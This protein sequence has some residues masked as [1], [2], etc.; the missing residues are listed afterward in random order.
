MTFDISEVTAIWLGTT[1]KRLAQGFASEGIGLPAAVAL[2]AKDYYSD[3]RNV[4]PPANGK[5]V[6]SIALQRGKAAIT[7]DLYKAFR[8]V[9]K[10]SGVKLNAPLQ[11]YLKQRNS[12]GRFAGKVRVEIPLPEFREIERQ[13]HSR[14]GWMQSGWNVALKRFGGKIPSWVSNKNGPGS[15]TVE[16]ST[17][18]M[19]ITAKNDVRS[20]GSISDMQRRINFVQKK[21]MQNL[22]RRA[23]RK[24]D[25]ALKEAFE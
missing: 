12:K 14:V 20:I 2:S 13:L 4:T 19:I 17:T 22:E 24:A 8:V 25:Q 9:Q 1:A 18:R 7:V 5:T 3:V 16:K 11:W 21:H 15:V 23:L 6:G 10:V